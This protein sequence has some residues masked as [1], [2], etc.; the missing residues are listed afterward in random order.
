MNRQEDHHTSNLDLYYKL[1]GIESSVA[2]LG[3]AMETQFKN[4]ENKIDAA[5]R[6]ADIGIAKVE[7]RVEEGEKRIDRIQDSFNNY[8]IRNG[9]IIG[10]ALA[11]WAVFG[12]AIK[13]AIGIIL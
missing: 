6:K 2:A 5:D 10:V 7:V 13:L 1:G 4:L 9:I 8:K 12:D 11:A 3:K